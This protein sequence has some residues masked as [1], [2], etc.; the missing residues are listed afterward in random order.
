MTLYEYE[1]NG[2]KHQVPFKGQNQYDALAEA[3]RKYG[4]GGVLQ[5]DFCAH[6]TSSG[7]TTH[8]TFQEGG[9]MTG[10]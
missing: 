10:K 8:R 7:R 5:V 6:K 4:E 3:E 1:I 2:Q 9:L